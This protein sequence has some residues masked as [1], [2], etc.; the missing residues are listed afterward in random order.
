[1]T[2]HQAKAWR[3]A[4]ETLQPGKPEDFWPF[5]TSEKAVISLVG[6][7]GKTT[8]LYYLA[9]CFARRGR[10]TVVM[11]TTKI[12]C[13]ETWCADMPACRAQWREG[14][15]AVCGQMEGGKFRA[16]GEGF[17]TALL[18]EADAVLI[19]A[20]G[21][22]RLPCKAPAEH[23]PVILPQTDTVIAVMGLDALEGTVREKCLRT[24]KVQAILGCEEDHPLAPEDL[25]ALLLSPQG[26]R[27]QVEGRDF[28]AV[29]N[30]CDTESHREAG[31]QVLKRLEE[32]GFHQAIL[33]T[34]M[35]VSEMFE[36][37][38]NNA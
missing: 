36:Y 26:S 35:T 10:R 1:M 14:R 25:A 29:L 24:D 15:Y 32:R 6:G 21:A 37:P 30:K 9:E 12:G 17:L 22:R 19:E 13:P 11:T 27:K 34:G 33:T 2:Y 7:G 31:R 5:L 4:G 16:P 8:L 20:D 18:A 23:E 38:T 3:L 28:Y